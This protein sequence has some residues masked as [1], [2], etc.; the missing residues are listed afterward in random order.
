[1]AYEDLSPSQQALVERL[2]EE[3]ATGNYSSEFIALATLGRGWFLQLQGQGGAEATE[4]DGFGET[5]L[6]ALEAEGYLTLI[7]KRQGFVGS[8]RPKAYDQYKLS[9]VEASGRKTGQPHVG[10]GTPVAPPMAADVGFDEGYLERLEEDS[11]GL[12]DEL[13]KNYE[14][15]R[16]QAAS[17]FRWTLIVSVGGF[18]FMAV[19]VT[20][21]L[22][23]TLAL[24][25][26]TAVGG[27]ISEFLAAVFFKQVKAANDRQDVYHND[28]I[29]RQ[30][31]L[32]AV[33][34]VRL[35]SDK[36]ERNRVVEAIVRQLLGITPGNTR[37]G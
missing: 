6:R 22:L 8:L 37:E 24:G 18:A 31:M 20:L 9:K 33:Q 1:M 10:L 2:V 19:G 11:R 32:D 25:T 12:L 23:E 34:V 27:A 28:L 35:M 4:V 21:A 26:A 3:L 17:W 13:H 16:K 29:A 30:K 15:S 36:V 7:Q 5:D 14:L